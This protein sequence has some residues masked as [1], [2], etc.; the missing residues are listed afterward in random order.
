MTKFY[1]TGKFTNAE[2]VRTDFVSMKIFSTQ[3][4]ARAYEL[5]ASRKLRDEGC[6]SVTLRINKG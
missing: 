3:E 4:K 1:V 5:Q 2:G 6:K